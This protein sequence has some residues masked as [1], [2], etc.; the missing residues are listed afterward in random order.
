MK[1]IIQI[2]TNLFAVTELSQ[3]T[4]VYEIIDGSGTLSSDGNT[5]TVSGGATIDA[6]NNYFMTGFI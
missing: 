1:N 5:Y 3:A 4:I 6:H 2:I